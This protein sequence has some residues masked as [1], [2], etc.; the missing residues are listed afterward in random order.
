MARIVLHTRI[1]APV[2]RCFLLSLSVDLHMLSTSGT[3]EKAVA[4]VTTGVMRLGDTVTWRA[5]HLGLTHQLTSRIIVYEEP[6]RFV[7]EM[8]EGPFRMLRHEHTFRELDDHHTLMVDVFEFSA[9]FGILGKLAE[10]LFLKRYLGK[11]LAQRNE[12][13]RQVAE[14]SLWERF[15]PAAGEV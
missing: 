3:R 15:L 2:Q 14:S 8:L 11:F 6:G 13:I 9:P 12:Y 5:R 1:T 10:A 4:G 7:D